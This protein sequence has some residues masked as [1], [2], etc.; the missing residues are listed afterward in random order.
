MTT[1][2]FFSALILVVAVRVLQRATLAEQE[3]GSL[4]CK[5]QG[6]EAVGAGGV[7]GGALGVGPVAALTMPEPQQQA[8]HPAEAAARASLEAELASKDHE[9]STPSRPARPVRLPAVA[10]P[11]LCLQPR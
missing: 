5:Q 1:L 4:S 11:F 10:T 6:L 9:V 2:A 8:Q 3:A 7:G